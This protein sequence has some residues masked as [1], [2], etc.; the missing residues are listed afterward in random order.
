M[1][2][3]VKI[4]S[5]FLF[6]YF[7]QHK[8]LYSYFSEIPEIP[9]TL[10]LQFR[11]KPISSGLEVEAKFTYGINILLSIFVFFLSSY[12]ISMILFFYIYT[13]YT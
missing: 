13:I 6:S 2:L 5:G 10:R 3:I 8:A 7:P 1:Y 9:Q 4:R 12:L 11:P